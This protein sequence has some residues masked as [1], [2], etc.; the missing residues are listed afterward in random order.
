M[1]IRAS[2]LLGKSFFIVLSDLWNCSLFLQFKELRIVRP[3]SLQWF[4]YF[5]IISK[6]RWGVMRPGK[7]RLD[8]GKKILISSGIR[9]FGGSKFR[10]E[11]T[12]RKCRPVFAHNILM[13]RGSEIRLNSRIW[14]YWESDHVHCVKTWNSYSIFCLWNSNSKLLFLGRNKCY[15]GFVLNKMI[16]EL[17]HSSLTVLTELNRTRGT[18]LSQCW[19]SWIELAALFSHSVD[20]VE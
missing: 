3:K 17:R 10:R 5:Y 14:L 2:S 4:S 18:V 20:R 13:A 19:Q 8:H 11:S 6:K 7:P 15:K 16:I 1:F 9:G 12:T